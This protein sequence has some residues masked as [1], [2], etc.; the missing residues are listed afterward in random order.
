[1]TNISLSF[2]YKMAAKINWHSLDMEQN[3]VSVTLC[4]PPIGSSR[5]VWQLVA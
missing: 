2:T 4:R 1:M 3:Y 5:I